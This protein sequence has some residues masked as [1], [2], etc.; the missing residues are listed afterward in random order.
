MIL[1]NI[2]NKKFKL[3]M[4][5]DIN[6]NKEKIYIRIALKYNGL[7]MTDNYT[8][9]AADYSEALRKF[10]ELENFINIK[11]DNIIMNNKESSV[12]NFPKGVSMNGADLYK[13]G[14]YFENSLENLNDNLITVSL[15][16]NF[17]DEIAKEIAALYRDEQ[18]FLNELQAKR[19]ELL[20]D[21]HCHPSRLRNE[22][23]LENLIEI[24]EQ[25][26]ILTGIAR[27]YNL[28]C[29]RLIQIKD[30]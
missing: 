10:E 27:T 22:D 8:F 15:S 14:I 6:E 28:I 30:K 26:L 21:I 2:D 25:S 1:K 17:R 18:E 16:D 12:E 4:K 11:N 7:G 20:W 19:N 13:L 24:R 3:T 29:G 23:V 5:L 9:L